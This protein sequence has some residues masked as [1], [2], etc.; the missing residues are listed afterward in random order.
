MALNFAPID[1]NEMT[2]FYDYEEL[3][4]E[5]DISISS[6]PL[7]N[8]ILKKL[9][10]RY[11][12]KREKIDEIIS[13]DFFHFMNDKDEIA[14]YLGN[15]HTFI[16][17]DIVSQ[18]EELYSEKSC[19]TPDYVNLTENT[20]TLIHK[21]IK[22]I[23]NDSNVNFDK[24]IVNMNKLRDYSKMVASHYLEIQ[25]SLR[26]KLK[27]IEKQVKA[28]ETIKD[29]FNF[30]SEDRERIIS[31]IDKYI[32]REDFVN[33]IKAYIPV[34][35]KMYVLLSLNRFAGLRDVGRGECRICFTETSELYAIV[36]CGHTFCKQCIDRT[37]R[38]ALCRIP[39]N[40]KIRIY[41]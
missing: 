17:P 5:I 2:N 7:I 18:I 32:E 6:Y 37:P 35:L 28:L 8:I 12:F 25:K 29:T 27:N 14:E 39:I 11:F 26:D 34:K 33:L 23:E 20:D 21:I 31:M 36:E 38:C 24:T 3:A 4:D 9:R 10:E 1:G 15:N 40:K 41:L 16:N 30:D 19:L 13:N 22:N